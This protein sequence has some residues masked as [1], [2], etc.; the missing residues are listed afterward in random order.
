MYAGGP[1]H[2]IQWTVIFDVALIL[3]RDF[4]M[5]LCIWQVKERIFRAFRTGESEARLLLQ[6]GSIRRICDSAF[7]S[8]LFKQKLRRT[9]M[10]VFVEEEEEEEEAQALSVSSSLDCRNI[11]C[12]L[13]ISGKSSQ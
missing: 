4:Y 8:I 3:G 6:K 10:W 11:L 12:T 1:D 2:I 7:S 13:Q 5:I 9:G